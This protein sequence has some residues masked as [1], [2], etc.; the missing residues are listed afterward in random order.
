MVGKPQQQELEAGD[1]PP[2]LNS[3]SLSSIVRDPSPGNGAP[4]TGTSLPIPVNLN[5]ITPH[6]PASRPLF[7]VVLD[8]M[9]L[10]ME[11]KHHCLASLFLSHRYSTD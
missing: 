7:Q 4:P 8:L 3:H 11:I 5:K 6:R 1:V 10:M 9:E 2:A